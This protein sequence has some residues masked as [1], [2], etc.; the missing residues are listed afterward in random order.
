MFSALIIK[1]AFIY[2]ADRQT[3]KGSPY[4]PTVRA[5]VR[6]NPEVT[7]PKLTMAASELGKDGTIKPAIIIRVH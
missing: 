3:L 1:V 7:S 5:S 2:V 6:L 4:V